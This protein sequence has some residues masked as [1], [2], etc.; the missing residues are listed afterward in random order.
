MMQ[1]LLRKSPCY[2]KLFWQIADKGL[3]PTIVSYIGFAYIAITPELQV[4]VRRWLP[5]ILRHHF[6][7]YWDIKTWM[8]FLVIVTVFCAI[9]GGLGSHAT[10]HFLKG[11]YSKTIDCY[12]LFSNDLYGLYKNLG[13]GVTER[14]SLYKL[15][16]DMFSCIGRYSDNE[17][18][19]HKPNRL[20]LK[21]QGVIAK[22]WETGSHE[23]TDAPDPEQNLNNWITYNKE[24]Y[25]YSE[26]HLQDIQMKSRAFSGIRL[27]NSQNKIVGVLIFESIKQ[28]GLPLSKIKKTFNKH[29]IE[30]LCALI[31]SLESHIPSLENAISEGF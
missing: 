16:I 26:E 6:L 10:V 1:E 22:A 19:N 30:R 13:L 12:K 18:F 31:D 15:E 20:Y 28:S 17:L 4:T 8:T 27:N 11:K 7:I 24:K 2:K 21:S 23:D 14:V 29:E 25:G 9:W 3:L 5:E